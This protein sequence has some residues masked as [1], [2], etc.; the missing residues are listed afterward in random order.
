MQLDDL[1]A[2]LLAE[3]AKPGP[4]DQKMLA[5]NALKAMLE[6]KSVLD[7]E[8]A[9]ARADKT[10]RL[11]TWSALLVPIVSVL[12]LFGTVWV[13]LLQANSARR[14]TENTEWRAL[15][16]SL[17]APSNTVYTDV[18]I[19][20]RLKSFAKSPVYSVQ[21]REIA[22]RLMGQYSNPEGFEDF[23]GY[24]FGRVTKDNFAD[25]W[26]VA[27]AL[28]QSKI[29]LENRCQAAVAAGPAGD[30]DATELVSCGMEMSDAE[31]A[32]AKAAYA[33]RAPPGASTVSF[34]RD[35][36]ANRDG[37]IGI[38]L[39]S[40]YLSGRIVEFITV[41]YAKSRDRIHHVGLD[42]SKGIFSFVDLKGADFSD[43]DI[44]DSI[45]DFVNLESANLNVK[46]FSGVQFRGCNWWDAKVIAPDLLV[47]LIQNSQPYYAD[48]VIEPKA[49][50]PEEY[51]R[52]VSA[53]C[54]ASHAD[55]PA[56]VTFGYGAA[57]R[58]VR[59]SL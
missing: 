2:E 5:A 9:R 16:T 21:A 3:A 26:S 20:P 28:S 42:L 7:A 29:R 30:A 46:S 43:S 59:L 35:M 13:G 18:T 25:V 44:S 6:A 55:C 39:E 12:A 31:F 51:G 19:A 10:E 36:D 52:K 23:F 53:L 8:E 24:V 57:A 27:R 37:I 58:S 45:F 17:E 40:H 33:K 48:R 15:L 4:L 32:D 47:Y 34:L 11:R 50:A 41:D 49:I 38:G 14:E 22:E 1:I 56:T 54:A